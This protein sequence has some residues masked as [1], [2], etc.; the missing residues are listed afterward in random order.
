MAGGFITNGSEYNGKEAIDIIIRPLKEHGLPEGIRVVDTERAG[1]KKM[2]FFGKLTK[3]LMPYSSGWQGG[4]GAT[5]KQKKFELEEFKAEVAYSKQDYA[6]TILEQ[7]TNIGGI[8]QNDITGTD[9]HNA[10]L[11]VFNRA[12]SHD[13]WRN[14]WFADKTKRHNA[15]GTY[16]DGS[17]AYAIGD[18]DQFY[19]QIDGVWKALF[20]QDA[21]HASATDDQVRRITIANGAVAMVDTVT[22]TGTSGTANISVKG[23]NYLATFDTNLTT[24]AANFVTSHSSELS[25]RNVTV[26]SS[27]ADVILT[28]SIAGVSLGTT[29]IVNV[30]TN[31]A[32]SVANTTGNTVAADLTTDEALSTFKSMYRNSTEELRA[33]KNAG[34]LRYYVTESMHF[35][36]EDTLTSGGTE[37]ARTQLVDGVERY[38]WNGI[39]VI[40]VA[41]DQTISSDFE[42]AY[43]H[44]AILSTP[45]NLSLVLSTGN[46]LAEIK[47]WMNPDANEN[48]QRTQFEMGA[49]FVLP[50]LITIAY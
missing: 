1:S 40:P 13:I 18:A 10:E 29:A 37:Q 31:L 35:N 45:Q 49:N 21:A 20:D 32:G 7:V 43:P 22:L 39:P 46:N 8:A 27:G 24:T 5:K 11:E 41:W 26:T 28:S 23:K 48:R 30:T 25:Q 3:I 36:Y 19:N 47:M 6:D 34:L 2:T 42:G 9:V 14:F 17:T 50:E 4:S 44:R 15:A 16:P 33:L 12:V 38:T